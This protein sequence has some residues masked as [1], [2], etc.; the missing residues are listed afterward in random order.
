MAQWAR[1]IG[2]TAFCQHHQRGDVE[3]RL[4]GDLAVDFASAFDHDNGLQ[5]GPLV[6]RL[7][8]VDIAD[9]GVVP[10]L[11]TAVISIDGL[12]RADLGVLVFQRFLLID[13]DLDILA[14]G[15]LIALQRDDVIPTARNCDSSG[16]PKSVKL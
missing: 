8:P 5:A 9:H 16:I 10:G 15:S 4:V 11:D 12:V 14:Q 6:A 2:P 1:I 13:E 3:A 7:Q